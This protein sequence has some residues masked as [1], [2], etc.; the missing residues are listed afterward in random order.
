MRT[1][2]LTV[3]N[4][5][6]EKILRDLAATHLVACDSEEEEVEER[7]RRYFGCGKGTMTILPSF[8]EPMEEF[9]E[10]ETDPKKFVRH[11][12][13]GKGTFMIQPSFYEPLEEF[14]EYE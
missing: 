12:G 2:D 6:A 5:Q 4:E 10:R 14:R 3:Q 1:L 7:H 9:E 11:A 8:Y 13:W